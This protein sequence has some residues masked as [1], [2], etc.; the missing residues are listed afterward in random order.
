[1][2]PPDARP[3]PGA[4]LP[5]D[6]AAELAE[7]DREFAPG[8][9]RR[10]SSVRRQAVF[11]SA[12]APDAAS[13]GRPDPAVP[14]V[15][16]IGVRGSPA[17]RPVAAGGSPVWKKVAAGRARSF[18][19]PGRALSRRGPPAPA[20]APPRPVPA[21]APLPPRA[22]PPVGLPPAAGAGPA[23]IATGWTGPTRGAA[24]R[25]GRSFRAEGPRR[26]RIPARTGPSPY[27][28][29]SQ[30]G[31]PPAAPP[32]PQPPRP[33]P[34]HPPPRPSLSV[35]PPR[36]APAPG[37]LS[38]KRLRQIYVEYVDAKRRQNESTA[39]ITYQSVA[40][41]LRDSGDKLRQKHGKAVDFEVAVKDGKT[42]LRPV[43]K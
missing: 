11:A 34:S 39:A 37:E 16:V 5:Q 30:A 26:R 41:S 36:P 42:I 21:G 7:L 15:A 31:A 27:P 18:A 19:C 17:P 40:K 43:L 20:P 24:R 33:A 12:T 9:G 13:P 6:L 22:M 28:D 38:E 35:A 29:L 32:R 23:A 2:P 10:R 8:V 3:E 25:H 14:R 4:P 1:M